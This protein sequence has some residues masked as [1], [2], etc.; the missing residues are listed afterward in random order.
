[1]KMKKS[2]R[3]AKDLNTIHYGPEP[4]LASITN[5]N[6]VLAPIF[7]WYRVMFD[8]PTKGKVMRDYVKA[9]YDKDFYRSFIGVPNSFMMTS[10]VSLVRQKMLGAKLDSDLE[11][12]LDST[13]RELQ[14]TKGKLVSVTVS[15]R[16]PKKSVQQ[17]M[18]DKLMDML[19]DVEYE[20]DQFLDNDF[21][22]D[23]NMYEWCQELDLNAKSTSLIP[24]HYELMI[25]E[26]ENEEDCEQ[27]KE[28]YAYLGIKGKRLL[29]EFIRSIIDDAERWAKNKRQQFKPRMRKSKLVDGTT[30]VKKLKFK[31]SD[32]QLKISS[33]NPALIIGARELW[34]YNT[35]N[36][37]LQV[38]RGKLDVRGT[39]IYGY[40]KGDAIEKSIGRNPTKY[41]KRC[42]DGG[43][44]VLKG[45]MNE[46]NSTDKVANGRVNEHCILLR[47]EK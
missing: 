30:R 5:E 41:I 20:I 23:F 12:R 26:L 37:K 22:S 25:D 29:I 3:S 40:A 36:K 47:V 35:K 44:L 13:I 28:A 1:M 16:K 21:K 6:A 45:L 42:L 10:F 18:E 39:T 38:Y 24:T 31:E 46:I 7:N 33:V 9:N 8:T 14:A 43:K 2:K 34:I 17:L 19:G 4:M 27:L 11:T 32:T 15:T